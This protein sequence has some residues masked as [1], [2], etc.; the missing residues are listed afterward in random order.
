MATF[1]LHGEYA[2]PKNL[3]GITPAS[4]FDLNGNVVFSA[5]S[6]DNVESYFR[7]ATLDTSDEVNA[8]SDD[9]QSF[10][11]ITDPHGNGNKQHSQAIGLYL[12]A[13]TK[14]FMLVLGGDYS[15]LDWSKTEYE[16]YTGPF[17]ESAYIKDIYAVFGNHEKLGGNEAEAKSCIYNDF[18]RDKTGLSGNLQENYYCFDVEKTKTRYVFLNTSNGNHQYRMAAAQ[19]SWLAQ[20]AILPDSDWSLVVIGHVSLAVMGGVTEENELNGT[21]VIDAIENCNGTIVGYICGHQHCDI[22]EL[23]GTFHHTTLICDKFE[24]SNYYPGISVTDR[25]TGTISEQAVSV[26]SINTTT[27]DVVIR[28]IGAGRNQTLSYN[29]AETE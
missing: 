27:K 12:L 3:A 21:D 4:A 9:W 7:Q 20:K 29:Y 28:R 8:L 15:I 25:V 5:Y 23:I 17:T 2:T 24:N 10:V 22:T 14:A 6:I 26:V 1:D 18:L 13:N 11:F 19:I 16:T